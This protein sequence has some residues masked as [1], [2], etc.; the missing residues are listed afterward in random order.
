[1]DF[2]V[3]SKEMVSEGQNGLVP[4]NV[5]KLSPFAICI[6]ELVEEVAG[7]SGDLV[8]FSGETFSGKNL[9]SP[10]TF[11]SGKKPSF[12]GKTFSTNNNLHLRHPSSCPATSISA[13]HHLLRQRQSVAGMSPEKMTGWPEN[14]NMK[15]KRGKKGKSKKAP[16]V[17]GVTEAADPDAV[18]NL[19]AEEDAS[20]PD[21]DVEKD[22]T[23]NSRMDIETPSSTGTDQPEKPTAVSS[24]GAAIDKPVGRLVYNRVKVKIKPSK[25]LEPQLTSSDAHTHSENTDKSSQLIGLEKQVVSEKVEDSANSVP[26]SNVGV[27]ATQAKKTGSIKIKSSKGFTSSLSPCNNAA[28]AQPERIQQKEPES[29]SRDSVYNKQELQASLEVVKKIMKMDAAEPFNVPVN[30]VALGIPDYFDVIK[31]PMD[32]GTICSNL[33][34]GLKYMNSEDVYKDVQYIWE[35]CYKYNNKGDYILELMKRVK[36]NFAKYWTA[37]GLYNEQQQG[38]S[39][40]LKDGNVSSHGKTSKSGHLK[41]KSRKRHG[42]KR[43]KDDC[44]CAICIMMRRRQEREKTMHPADDQTETSDGLVKTEGTSA[45]GSPDTSS[46]TDNS[47][48]QDADGE[49]EDKGGEEEVKPEKEI[50]QQEEKDPTQTNKENAIAE[51]SQL[52]GT[53]KHDEDVQMAEAGDA[54]KD[55]DVNNEEKLENETASV[56]H[57]KPKELA[58]A[59]ERAKLYENLHKRYENPMVLE[60]CASLFP[61]NPKSLWTRPHSLVP[62]RGSSRSS[63]I[64]AAIASFI[65]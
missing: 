29:L 44:L 36:K 49:M 30:P 37:A 63:L 12:S 47:Q 41:H 45:V 28:G 65:K 61:E 21:D 4:Q 10:A 14:I 27:S 19:S 3:T 11:I 35:N 42:V 31:T 50:L 48:N 62:H 24:T 2:A 51:Q 5:S 17:V 43:H 38:H 8:N 53:G 13:T 40:D 18:N 56:E 7:H 34:N 52:P 25:A 16:K 9:S 26:E 33:E 1:M 20:G 32:F 59:G 64:G 46:S 15:R 54:T 23:T 55:D 39:G 57:Q 58:D 60:L 6:G 22:E